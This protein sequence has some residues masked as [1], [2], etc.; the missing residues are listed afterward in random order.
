MAFLR[1][2]LGSARP[3]DAS[4]VRTAASAP[5]AAHPNG[6]RPDPLP[7]GGARERWAFE[8]PDGIAVLNAKTRN[9][10][11][12]VRLNRSDP[13]LLTKLV[14][15]EGAELV[16]TEIRGDDGALGVF[17]DDTPLGWLPARAAERF[18][19]LVREYE[20][21]GWRLVTWTDVVPPDQ[22]IAEGASRSGPPLVAEVRL[23]APHEPLFADAY[24]A[25]F[26]FPRG[27]VFARRKTPEGKAEHEAW[28]ASLPPARETVVVRVG[29][30]AVRASRCGWEAFGDGELESRGLRLKDERSVWLPL[31]EVTEELD[32]LGARIIEVAGV[33]HHRDHDAPAFTAEQTV[34]LVPE[35]DNFYDRNAIA[36][37]SAD[38][39]LMAGYVPRGDAAWCHRHGGAFTGVVVWEY[40]ATRD[41]HDR[42]GLRVLIA[43]LPITIQPT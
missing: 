3:V 11:H 22:S 31:G 43:P 33:T 40:R 6:G 9:V 19:P 2:L 5:A 39:R 37:R 8:A 21:R 28:V 42:R 29:E 10:I 18:A 17:S 1:R 16:L 27:Q 7:M 24:D 35:P 23:P 12:A 20:A 13:A 14:G 36:V 30:V 15:P 25:S 41:A 38:G 26:A 34:R 32:R 4:S